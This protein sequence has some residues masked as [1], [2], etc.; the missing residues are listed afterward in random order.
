[1]AFEGFLKGLLADAEGEVTT[2]TFD[3]GA[4]DVGGAA[5]AAGERVGII[6]GDE[7]AVDVVHRFEQALGFGGMAVTDDV[8]TAA[9]H[10]GGGLAEAVEVGGVFDA[11][12]VGVGQGFVGEEGEDDGGFG[13]FFEGVLC[14]SG[15]IQIGIGGEVGADGVNDSFGL[16]EEGAGFG[17]IVAVGGAD[18]VGAEADEGPRAFEG[19]VAR[20]VFG[21][22]VFADAGGDL[23]EV[24]H[25]GSTDEAD[26]TNYLWIFRD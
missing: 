9:A 10:F 17:A 1:V 23:V 5:E 24:F 20:G 8:E 19:F 6:D 21:R 14:V 26:E 22:E 15:V 13:K 7:Q 11:E 4:N 16:S 3:D 18:G 25:G 2:S 12:G